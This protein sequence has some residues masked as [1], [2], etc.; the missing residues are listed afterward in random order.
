MYL[1]IIGFDTIL[2]SRSLHFILESVLNIDST[3]YSVYKVKSA[4]DAGHF[5]ENWTEDGSYKLVEFTLAR[6]IY[7]LFA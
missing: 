6:Y 1:H 4:S 3:L 2:G 5:L 7:E